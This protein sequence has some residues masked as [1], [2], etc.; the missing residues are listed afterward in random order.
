MPYT[1]KEAA[2]TPHDPVF[3]YE[4][5]KYFSIKR[6]TCNFGSHLADLFTLKDLTS[7]MKLEEMT[8]E[9]KVEELLTATMSHEMRNPLNAMLQMHD[10]MEP[11]IESEQGKRGWKVSKNSCIFLLYLIND[12]QDYFSIKQGTF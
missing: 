6:T 4:D 7:M 3:I 12:M 11:H 10:V 8:T 9:K 5:N 1:M 2:N